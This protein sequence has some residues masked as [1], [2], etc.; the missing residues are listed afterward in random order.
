MQYPG[1]LKIYQQ[2][3]RDNFMLPCIT[4]YTTGKT[5]T[6]GDFART[7]AKLHILFEKCGIQKGDRVALLG[8]NNT[9]WVTV[10]M[11]TVTYGAVIVPILSDF[12]PHD[13]QH[14]INHS[15]SQLLFI[16]DAL[17]ES[18]DFTTTPDVKAAISTDS[19]KL[20]AERDEN[21]GIAKVMHNLQ[22][23]FKRR[24]PK[25]YNPAD[26]VYPDMDRDDMSILNYTSGTTG[27]SK[28]VMLPYRSLWGNVTYGIESRLHYK[29]SR[30]LSFLP[31]AH[32]YGCAFD[33]LVPLAVGSHITL[34]GR[35]PTPMILMKAFGEVKPSLIV[36]V[37]LILEKIYRKMVV[38]ALAKKGMRIALAIPL[39]DRAIYP[40]IRNK[41]IK[42]LGGEFSQVI[43]GGAALNPEVED[44][45]IKIHFPLTVGY[46]MTECAPLI[47]FTDWQNFIPHSVGR[48]L[49][50]LMEAKI[51]SDDP[52]TPGE[53][54]VRGTN[55]ML[56]Y[57]RRPDITADTIEEGGW[58]HTG[59]MG[60]LGGPDG[61][62]I[63][64]RGRYKTMILSGTGQNIY[65]EEIEAK[66][67][68]MPYVAESLVIERNGHL[69]ALVFPDSE[70][71]DRDEVT[72]EQL[73]E[74]M[75]NN[76]RELNTLVAPY[77]QIK[78]IHLV[79]EEFQKTPKRSI[80][81]F[82]YS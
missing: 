16:S 47:S 13:C 72:D 3:M 59:D 68:N 18:V 54:L 20:L 40:L 70:A 45:L 66:L 9:N 82:L 26:I 57:F 22:R 50:G 35:T 2:S 73:P 10:F 55:V 69:V 67:N 63:F 61:Q 19:L 32:A 78:S 71:T 62:T 52:Q 1:I 80:K 81:R 51:L 44:F 42:A 25:G 28:G 31:L 34:L 33:M 15:G 23:T 11:A 30:V 77:E 4:D 79:P 56:G 39:L 76:R 7:M 36:T 74:V 6:Y 27:F 46:G 60:T 53:I 41:L 75:E 43:V 58:M 8:K 64:I 37:P 5:I 65:P 14:I 21:G 12:N 49:P 24:Y 17:W 48:T 38:P 29:G